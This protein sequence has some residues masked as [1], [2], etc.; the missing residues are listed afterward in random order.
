MSFTTPYYASLSPLHILS[1]ATRTTL[2]PRAYSL[3]TTYSFELIRG[4]EVER[5]KEGGRGREEEDLK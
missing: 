1:T 2:T 5:E 3:A 4:R